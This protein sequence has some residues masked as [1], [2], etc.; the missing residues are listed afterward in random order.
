MKIFDSICMRI[1]Q[2]LTHT[3]SH[4]LDIEQSKD[5]STLNGIEAYGNDAAHY[6][7]VTHTIFWN[8]HIR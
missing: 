6:E 8:Y 4:T 2:T 1:W 3:K 7:K 5:L